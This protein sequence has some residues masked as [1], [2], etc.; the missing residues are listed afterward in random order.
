MKIEPFEMERWQSIHEHH[1][2]VNLSDSGVHPLSAR[3]LVDDAAELGEV[4]DQR[5]IYTQ[6]NGSA[7]DRSGRQQA[8]DRSQAYVTRRSCDD[9]GLYEAGDT[10]G[11]TMSETMLAICR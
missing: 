3:E 2:E 10:L 4:L 6:T 9:H 1:V 8:L 11:L 5:L 7:F